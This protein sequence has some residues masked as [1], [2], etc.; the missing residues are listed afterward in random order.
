MVE[1]KKQRTYWLDPEM[2]QAIEE[3]KDEAGAASSSDFVR[4]A[5][6]FYIGYLYAQKAEDYLTPL[7]AQV[8]KS[9][10]RSLE[11]HLSEM[12]FKLAVENGVQN[13]ILAQEYEVSRETFDSLH[14]QSARQV[15]ETNGILS[16][17]S[18]VG[19]DA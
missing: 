5:L 15:A 18:A 16:L 4:K 13:L 1:K 3:L 6:E 14:R 17:E 9:E 2:I 10:T 19:L 7:L 11:Q 8:L 12:L